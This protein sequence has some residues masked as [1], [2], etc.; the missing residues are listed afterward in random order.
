M[1][2]QAAAGGRREPEIRV[3]RGHPALNHDGRH[4][5]PGPAVLSDTMA[6]D[7]RVNGE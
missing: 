6:S 3:V 7:T 2:A 5:H 1:V 4:G